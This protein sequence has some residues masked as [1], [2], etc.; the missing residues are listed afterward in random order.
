MDIDA[1]KIKELCERLET[2]QEYYN[3]FLFETVPADNDALEAAALI[4]SLSLRVEAEKRAR[5]EAEA[6]A[7]I[8]SFLTSQTSSIKPK[9]FTNK[10]CDYDRW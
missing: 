7:L 5:E 1:K 2:R 3:N 4:R 9:P 8:R 6:A 10:A